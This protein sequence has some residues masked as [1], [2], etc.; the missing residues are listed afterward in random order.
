MFRSAARWCVGWFAFVAVAVVAV[1]AVATP[2]ARPA[3]LRVEDVD[4]QI[5]AC[6]EVVVGDASGFEQLGFN[7]LFWVA[8]GCDR[9]LSMTPRSCDAIQCVE[10]D[11][12]CGPYKCQGDG[13]TVP[14]GGEAV[15]ADAGMADARESSYVDGAVASEVGADR[16]DVAGLDA[17]MDV[18]S[19]EAD[20]SR[21]A[22]SSGEADARTSSDVAADTRDDAIDYGSLPSSSK[23]K[24]ALADLGLGSDDFEG[25][26]VTVRAF[27]DWELDDSQTGTF[28]V[29]LDHE[30]AR[31]PPGRGPFG[32]GCEAGASRLLPVSWVLATLTG[33]LLVRRLR[34]RGRG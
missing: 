3:Y 18:S 5:P 33:L 11:Q 24:V 25:E 6:A 2:G 27:I 1:P 34:S 29:D 22:R 4:G 19:D 10:N 8:N 9:D 13:V 32:C 26:N 12:P 16:A 21:D 17:A 31:R 23:V 7:E 28:H 30:P 20:A 14:A 15:V